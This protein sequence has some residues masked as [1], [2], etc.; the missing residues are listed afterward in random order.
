MSFKLS[1]E[2]G[3]AITVKVNIPANTTIVKDTL[4]ALDVINKGVIPAT[5]SSTTALVRFVAQEALV[6][7]ATAQKIR[8][9][10]LE[11]G[12]LW[13]GDCTNATLA[14]QLFIRQ[15]LT[16]AGTINNSTSDTAGPT[17]IVE[18]VQ[19][20]GAT[21]DKKLRCLIRSFSPTA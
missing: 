15:A 17:G 7:T 8:A 12:Q 18:P 11:S 19:I 21:G 9:I 2:S 10:L 14:S 6:S 4:L 13:E 20:I 3:S 16:D 5:S 1:Q